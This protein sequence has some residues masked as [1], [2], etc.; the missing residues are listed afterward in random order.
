MA[1]FMLEQDEDKDETMQQTK[2]NQIAR[3]KAASSG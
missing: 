1:F 3:L 2:A